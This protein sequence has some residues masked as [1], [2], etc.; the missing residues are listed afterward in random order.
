MQYGGLGWAAGRYGK[1]T[2][3]LKG[4]LARMHGVF[5]QVPNGL[6]PCVPYF[7]YFAV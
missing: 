4:I 6:G 3:G 5:L 1:R 7:K 2:G